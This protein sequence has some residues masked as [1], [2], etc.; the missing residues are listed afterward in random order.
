MR[1]QDTKWLRLKKFECTQGIHFPTVLS[2]HARYEVAKKLGKDTSQVI[3]QY[4]NLELDAE[5]CI[6][7]GQCVPWC[8]YKLNIPEMMKKAHEDLKNK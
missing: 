6:E 3:D 7:C 4:N 2:L 8:E 5:A 1:T